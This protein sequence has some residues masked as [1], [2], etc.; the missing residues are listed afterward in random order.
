MRRTAEG[1]I[2]LAA[3]LAACD[4][5]TGPRVEDLE[6]S[7]AVLEARGDTVRLS[8]RAA[9]SPVAASWESLEPSVVTVTGDGLA[10]A[11]GAGRARVR[12]RFGGAEAQAT[13]DVL[14]PVDIRISQL[15][16]VTDPAGVPGV[17]M[18][19]R[20]H[21]GRGYY[22]LELW[23]LDPH[24]TKRR[25]VSYDTETEAAP[26]LD[27]EHINY[28]SGEAP[29]WVVAYSREPFAEEPVRSACVRVDGVAGCPSDLPD[30]RSVRSVLVTPAAEVLP[31]G[32]SVQYQARAYDENGFEITGRSVTW[33]TSS[34]NIIRL[35][36]LGMATALAAG[37]GQV[38]ATIDGV[39][40]AVGLTVTAAGQAV[41]SVWVGPESAIVTVGDTVRYTA[42][43]FDAYGTELTGLTVRWSTSTPAIVS[44]SEGGVATALAVGQGVVVVNV[45][46]FSTN[47]G[48]TVGPVVDQLAVY[49]VGIL[50][51][52]ETFHFRGLA[53][54]TRGVPVDG[55]D[56]EWTSS[57]PAVVEVDQ[58][59]TVQAHAAGWAAVEAVAGEIR[60]RITVRVTSAPGDAL[61]L[62][63]QPEIGNSMLEV[64]T[65]GPAGS[66]YTV[67]YGAGLREP[68]ASP[69]GRR[70]AFVGET[71]DGGRDIF[72]VN[73][74]GTGLQRLTTNPGPDD[75]PAWSP[76]GQSIAFRSIVNG[77]MDVWIIQVDG[78]GLRNLTA[79]GD[80]RIQSLGAER[81][82]WSPDGSWVAYAW[83]VRNMSP[84]RS[85]LQMTRRDG[86]ETR[87]ITA[88]GSFE[89]TEPSFSPLGD[90]IVFRRTGAGAVNR[91]M[92][93][94]LS[95]N[96]L[97]PGTDLGMGRT[98]KWSPD[99]EWLVYVRPSTVVAGPGALILR[100]IGWEEERALG[101]VLDVGWTPVG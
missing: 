76:D 15:A 43:A 95:G 48:I 86:S 4:G 24:G 64:M 18:R 28:L 88:L 42:R 83:G 11:V 16:L 100:R 44:V 6:V 1:W 41:D 8:A 80:I 69:D 52:G 53:L 14:T 84:A 23:K 34:P 99:G 19:I 20:N 29:D 25:L 94:D 98:P 62:S 50:F 40:T 49:S 61:L 37:Y 33:H 89:D 59:G 26:G 7:S 51:V 55:V 35:D 96:L 97:D 91:I 57:N 30:V 73:A 47:V 39:S 2:V 13:I 77:L 70:F 5:G 75:Q 67:H 85:G 92:M 90:R 68:V 56:I 71:Q 27:I 17:R 32:D 66:R 87:V 3:L 58:N 12:A 81:P 54:D 82:A 74:D 31:V 9:G 101:S 22:A 60:E 38:E 65:L 10:T 93:T 46:G 36:D 78:S 72:L 21:G 63:Q 79:L 45:E